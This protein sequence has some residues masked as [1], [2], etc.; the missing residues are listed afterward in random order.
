MFELKIEISNSKGLASCT[1]Q[2]H[3]VR[4]AGEAIA[5]CRV[6]FMFV[7]LHATKFRVL[8]VNGDDIPGDTMAAQFDELARRYPETETAESRARKLWGLDEGG[9]A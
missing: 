8:S 9:D 2:L 3:D 1:M 6:H 7:N 5:A 4:D